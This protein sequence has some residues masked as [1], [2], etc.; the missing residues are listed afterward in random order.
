MDARFD[1]MD[2]RLK[3]ILVVMLFGFTLLTSLGLYQVSRSAATVAAP[4]YLQEAPQGSN[5]VE[6]K[7]QPKKTSELR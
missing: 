5:V 3:L 4:T 6:P 2:S 1:S 7:P